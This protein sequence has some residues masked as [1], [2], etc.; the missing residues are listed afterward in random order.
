MIIIYKTNGKVYT[1]NSCP[2]QRVRTKFGDIL[3]A[4]D[5]AFGSFLYASFQNYLR[6]ICVLPYPNK[7]HDN[8]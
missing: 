5:E 4:R 7:L 3:L 1:L 8:W 2:H 6:D